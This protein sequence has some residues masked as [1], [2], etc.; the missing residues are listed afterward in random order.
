MSPLAVRQITFVLHTI[1]Q[2]LTLLVWFSVRSLL[3][4]SGGNDLAKVNDLPHIGKS[5]VYFYF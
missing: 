2:E 5:A 3:I 4:I 1:F